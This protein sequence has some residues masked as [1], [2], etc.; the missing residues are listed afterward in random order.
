MAREE[1]FHAAD[2]PRGRPTRARVAVVIP[3][4]K[5]TGKTEKMV[6][7]VSTAPNLPEAPFLEKVE[8]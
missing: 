8:P 2:L 1:F 7:K 5:V 6:P 3:C 4:Y